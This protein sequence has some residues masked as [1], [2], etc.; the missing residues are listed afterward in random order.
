MLAV[1]PLNKDETA[2]GFSKDP[3]EASAAWQDA[4]PL[5]A[6]ICSSWAASWAL[7]SGVSVSKM[8][9]R[10]SGSVVRS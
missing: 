7:R 5:Q 4:P 10:S 8:F 3:E 2:S 9:W 1:Q 6:C